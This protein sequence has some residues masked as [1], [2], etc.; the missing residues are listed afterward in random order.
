MNIADFQLLAYAV[1][2][3]SVVVSFFNS[4]LSKFK[5]RYDRVDSK[6]RISH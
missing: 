3:V 5:R 1:V 4:L 2:G 6:I